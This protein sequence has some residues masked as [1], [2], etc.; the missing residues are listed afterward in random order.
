[1]GFAFVDVET[2]G[3]NPEKYDKIV[4]IA[5]VVTDD[6]LE[7][8]QGY[9]SLINPERD[10]GPTRIH[11]ISAS[12]VVAAPTFAE[13]AS[14]I[15]GLLHNNVVVAHN[16]SFD[17]K[18]RSYGL[19]SAGVQHDF[20][21]GVCSMALARA[22]PGW[23]LKLDQ[24]VDYLGIERKGASHSAMSDTLACLEV[25]K[26]AT[27]LGGHPF[28]TVLGSSPQEPARSLRRNTADWALT[29]RSYFRSLPDTGSVA[30]DNYLNLVASCLADGQLDAK[31]RQDLE[32]LIRN[33]QFEAHKLSE[34]H[35]RYVYNVIEK[36]SADGV[37]DDCEWEQ[38]CT[39]A[40]LLGVQISVG[41]VMTSVSLMEQASNYSGAITA[42]MAVCLTGEYQVERSKLEAAAQSAGLMV[43]SGVSHKVDLLVC[44]D[45]SS[46]S[47]KAR[48]ARSYNVPIVDY[49]HLVAFLRPYL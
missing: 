7:P 25:A 30:A 34:L 12:Q 40:R 24:L 5:I 6:R 36:A 1:M 21:T 38:I 29:T 47:A 32:T 31:E 49:E 20:G 22:Y 33:S 2:T 43:K 16:L 13:V 15:A 27:G 35:H 18:F 28:Q 44:S 45:I 8:V 4:E 42:G 37:V 3:L 41:D 26:V 14:H 10:V 23:P 48:K 46:Q 9:E 17:Q 39:A 11:G 19:N